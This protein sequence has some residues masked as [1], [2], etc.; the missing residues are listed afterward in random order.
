MDALE[1]ALNPRPSKRGKKWFVF[2][3]SDCDWGPLIAAGDDMSKMMVDREHT[4]RRVKG[5]ASLLEAV[6]HVSIKHLG[7]PCI[8]V[9]YL[10]D[11]GETR[12]PELQMLRLR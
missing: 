5:F 10:S 11:S 3:R 7:L 9:I 4:R 8:N 2:E 1:A 12:H 6:M